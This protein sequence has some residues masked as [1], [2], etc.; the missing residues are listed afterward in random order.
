MAV[1]LGATFLIGANGPVN[2]A[3]Q[4]ILSSRVADG[5]RE[6]TTDSLYGGFRRGVEEAAKR[7]GVGPADV[8]RLLPMAEVRALVERL[9]RSQ[10]SAVNAWNLHAGQIG[11]FLKGV[12]DLTADGRAPDVGLCLERL[13]KKLVRDKELSQPLQALAVDVGAWQD[14]I[15]RCRDLLDDGDVLARA[16]RMR[17]LKRVLLIAGL[18]GVIVGALGVVV[19]VR[20]ARVRIDEVLGAS[21]A[22][23]VEGLGPSDV[24]RASSDQR[25]LIDARRGACSAERDREAKE[26]EAAKQREERARAEAAAKKEAEARCGAL[27]DHLAAGKL[28]GEDEAIAGDKAPLLHRIA[29]S[30]IDPGDYG[31]ADPALPCAGTEGAAKLRAAFAA[32]VLASPARWGDADDL[33]E[34]VASTLADHAAELPKKPKQSLAWHANETARK[35]LRSSPDLMPKAQ[36]LCKL[37]EA[38]A[39]KGSPDCGRVLAPA[40]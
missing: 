20:A 31:P 14:V 15:V 12:A 29:E 25:A 38:F 27:A 35:A 13:A 18:A 39:I 7:V 17:R 11:G 36:R 28:T 6:L 3:G 1:R 8:E 2:Y 24:G 4:C 34:L 16:Y 9:N 30:A 40:Q 32:A 10:Q 23:A 5:L 22:C 37:R 19:W 26:R 33:S 21:E